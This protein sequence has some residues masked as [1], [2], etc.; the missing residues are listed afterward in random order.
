MRNIKQSDIAR[1]LNVSRVTV[2]KALRDCP[3]ISPDMKKKVKKVASKLGYVP[4]Y[5][6]R[7][8]QS[9]KTQT[10]GVVVPDISN[11]FF[12]YAIHG[13]MDAASKA[14]Y[15]IVLTA[16]RENADIEYDNIMTL[17]SMRVDGLLVAVSKET[18]DIK[19]FDT[20]RKMNI[21]LVF[22]DRSIEG[23]GF[24]S[25]GIDD[26]RSACRLINHVI[27][28]GYQKIA[29]LAGTM[30]VGIGRERLA[31]Y[32]DA[33]RDHHI[34]LRNEWII[35][36]GFD[37]QSGYQGF[38]QLYRKGPMPE[39]IY[40][41]NDGA[42]R[43][44]YKAIQEVGLRIPDDIGVVAFSHHEFAELLYP[45]LT[46][47]D[48]PPVLIG[49]SAME[50]LLAEIKEKPARARKIILN[51]ELVPNSSLLNRSLVQVG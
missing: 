7:N 33:L 38:M 42:A 16:S 11:S 31:G 34:R 10:I 2:S 41:V 45:R 26:R 3:D 40:A 6:A 17:I 19:I 39:V 43:G 22:F 30:T 50:L 14:G 46:I 9:Q 36:S 5:T 21:P 49:Q 18:E 15:H 1:V 12:S 27:E 51:T 13:I 48:A 47:I 44:A 32:K 29:H 23:L 20:V 4:N 37:K 24:S 28:C 8:L 25:V 35:E